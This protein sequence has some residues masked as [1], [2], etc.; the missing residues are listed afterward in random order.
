MQFTLL[1]F[2]MDVYPKSS[3]GGVLTLKENNYVLTGDTLFH[4]QK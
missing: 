4:K 3:V 1:V 2:S